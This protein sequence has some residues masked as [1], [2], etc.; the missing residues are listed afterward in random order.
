M[1]KRREVQEIL[2]ELKSMGAIVTLGR[3]GHYK[4]RH[5]ETRRSVSIAAT[6]HNERTVYND[7]ARLRRIG[8]DLTWKRDTSRTTRRGSDLARSP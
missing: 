2:K 6:P 1:S 4:V 7:L 5:P 3:S 8:Y